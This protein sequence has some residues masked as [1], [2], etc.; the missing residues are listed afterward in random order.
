MCAREIWYIQATYDFKIIPRHKPGTNMTLADSLSRFHISESH[1]QTF[2]KLTTGKE[3]KQLSVPYDY[4]H[5]KN[6]IQLYRTIYSYVYIYK[7]NC[8]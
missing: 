7:H 5:L 8:H 2:E 3:Y 6:D 4:F 1:R